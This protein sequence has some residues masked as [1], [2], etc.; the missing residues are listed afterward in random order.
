M[1]FNAIRLILLAV[2]VFT[3]GGCGDGDQTVIRENASPNAIVTGRV[4]D[5]S[6]RLPVG[7]AVVTLLCNGT[8]LTVTTS[9]SSDPDLAGTFTFFGI[10]PTSSYTG[11]ELTISAPGYAVTYSGVQVQATSDNMPI[12]VALGN[13]TLGKPCN[14]T[15]IVSDQ[16]I[17]VQGIVVS[18][19]NQYGYGSSITG[20]TDANGTAVL[21]GLNQEAIY[22][23]MT[24]PKYD[25]NGNILYPAS[26]FNSNY[27]PQYS[28][29]TISI[30]V[31]QAMSGGAIQIIGSNLTGNITTSTT[32]SLS[33][34]YIKSD[35]IIRIVFNYPVTLTGSVSATYMN[36]LVPASD[37][38]YGKVVTVTT[39]A[40]SLDQS[41]TILTI[42]NSSPYIKNQTYSFNIPVVA[43]SN[44]QTRSYNFSTS[45]PFFVNPVYVTDDSVTGLGPATIF[46][47]DNF[48][49]TSGATATSS[50]AQVY[51][52]FPE[53]VFGTYRVISTKDGT[54]VTLLSSDPI[55][56]GF[57]GETMTYAANSGGADGV[58]VFK[59]PINYNVYLPDNRTGS[60][61]E[62]TIAF[63]VM[64]AEGNRFNNT[65]TLPVQ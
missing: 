9:N 39:L 44:G 26:M 2:L 54:V 63:D 30:A 55:S 1:F 43:T 8:K 19:S 5:S 10:V 14:V 48:N 24:S 51:V 56:F 61:S 59:L 6:T 21:V 27:Q 47:A 49:G 34:T 15:V 4:I 7:G 50:P 17:P 58:V 41:G 13:I 25:A 11:Y 16:G 57:S 29:R 18:A 32:S 37:P 31:T 52:V 46:K 23:I 33:Q 36:D 40:G 53:K 42:A 65:V 20:V 62:V 22:Q 60:P 12:S 45:S 38:D 64:D 28:A 3:C 35:S